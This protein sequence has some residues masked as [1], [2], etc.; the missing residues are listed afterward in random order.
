MTNDLA[1]DVSYFRRARFRP[2]KKLIAMDG[3]DAKQDERAGEQLY[4][5]CRLRVAASNNGTRAAR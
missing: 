1:D 3:R 4:L 5:S 2:D